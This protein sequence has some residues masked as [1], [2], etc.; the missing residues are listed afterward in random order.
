MNCSC[1]CW[2]QVPLSEHWAVVVQ[3]PVYYNVKSMVLGAPTKFMVFD[4]QPEDGTLIHVVRLDGTQVSSLGL[5]GAGMR[6]GMGSD[7]GVDYWVLAATGRHP[8]PRSRAGWHWL[9]MPPRSAPPHAR[10][11]PRRIRRLGHPPRS[12]CM[13]Q[14]RGARRCSPLL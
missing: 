8:Q 10:A 14:I 5:G 3:N 2:L 4:W 7:T 12:G 6:A 1:M 9:V 13:V 11:I